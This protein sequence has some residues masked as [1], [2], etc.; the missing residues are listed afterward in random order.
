VAIRGWT[1]KTK[2]E[3]R[4]KVKKLEMELTTA[5]KPEQ[6]AASRNY[7]TRNC[8]FVTMVNLR[9]SFEKATIAIIPSLNHY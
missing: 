7:F 9:A 8:V 4:I 3:V 5:T 1:E 2:E 6:K